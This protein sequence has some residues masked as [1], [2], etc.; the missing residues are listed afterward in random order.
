M[1]V[2]VPTCRCHLLELDNCELWVIKQKKREDERKSPR[3]IK[4][5][6]RKRSRRETKRVG[7][8]RKS[9]DEFGGLGSRLVIGQKV[10]A[11]RSRCPTPRRPAAVVNKPAGPSLKQKRLLAIKHGRWQSSGES[12]KRPFSR[13]SV[14]RGSVQLPKRKTLYGWHRFW[15]SANE[16]VADIV[17]FQKLKARKSHDTFG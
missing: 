2:P 3:F 1:T 4:L 14:V 15:L 7:S 5:R 10:D 6:R 12:I 8:K 9:M 16:R 11:H 13:V 17:I